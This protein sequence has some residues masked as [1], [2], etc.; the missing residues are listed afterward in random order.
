MNESK[1]QQRPFRLHGFGAPLFVACFAR[2]RKHAFGVFR[3]Q[4]DKFFT[5]LMD[6]F[7]VSEINMGLAGTSL[8]AVSVTSETET[9][10]KRDKLQ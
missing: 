9:K 7:I 1:R 2:K 6:R 8:D 3:G 4:M 5:P 10:F